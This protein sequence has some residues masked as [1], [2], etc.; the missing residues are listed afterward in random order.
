MSAIP[1]PY[2]ETPLVPSLYLSDLTGANV[3]LKL[4]L[5]QP[6]GSFKSRGLGHLVYKTVCGENPAVPAHLSHA[7]STTPPPD[8]YYHFFSPSGG[9]AG[10]AT[11][12]AARLY[13]QRCTVC[14]PTAANP[15]MVARIRK[16]GATVVVHGATIADADAH[17]RDVLMPACPDVAVYC[18]PYNDPLVW[19]GNSSIADEI[20]AQLSTRT[21]KSTE[22]SATLKVPTAVAPLPTPS[23]S[24]K[25]AS[26][27]GAL[28]PSPS[29]SSLH[30]ADDAAG[31]SSSSSPTTTSSQS[32][33]PRPPRLLA[34]CSVGGGGLYNGLGIGFAR[35]G[36]A[37][38][39]LVAVET[40]GCATL[41]RSI[42]AGGAQVEIAA[43]ATIATSLATRSVTRETIAHATA[44]KSTTR[45]LV[46]SDRD[47]AAACVAFLEDHKML[48][49]PAC[50]AALA[51][52]YC[53]SLNAAF[54]DLSRADTVVV[55]VC[56]GTSISLDI[57][58]GYADKFDIPM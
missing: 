53:G 41:A 38:A 13:R 28:P 12:Y 1:L 8:N 23:T 43:P 44:A 52:L 35:G 54:P 33:P 49:E 3:L 31:F 37:D 19:E 11:A 29:A 47:A 10:C 2:V 42:A 26:T 24:P 7:T 46:V 27:T 34:V 55:V 39:A 40:V 15:I 9:N 17:I 56:G 16:T 25:L 20:V 18:H 58:K 14:L 57:L 30:L 5:T 48:V 21:E 50:G 45:S 6:S 4:E 36:R 22:T 32:P 51:P